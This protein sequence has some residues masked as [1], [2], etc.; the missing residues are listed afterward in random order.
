MIRSI[1]FICCWMSLAWAQ[2]AGEIAYTEYFSLDLSAE[3]EG[4]PGIDAAEIPKNFSHDYVATF[5]GAVGRFDL[6]PIKVYT[7]L[8]GGV[9][10]VLSV[11]HTTV[12]YWDFARRQAASLLTVKVPQ[13]AAYVATAPIATPTLT[14]TGKTKEILGQLCQKATTTYQDVAYTLWIATEIEATFSPMPDLAPEKGVVLEIESADLSFKA[15]KLE[16]KPVSPSYVL[17]PGGAT[18]VT[19]EE[20]AEKRTAASLLT[21]P[22]PAAGDNK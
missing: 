18:P 1:F 15:T 12:E 4:V 7:S 19:A 8:Q 14:Y 16:M 5:S 2:Q 21:A 13:T 6:V 10:T 22:Q 9:E 20:L 11:P 3:L 17:L